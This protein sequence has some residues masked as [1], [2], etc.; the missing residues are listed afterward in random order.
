MVNKK[1]GT[2]KEKRRNCAEKEGKRRREDKELLEKECYVIRK[3]SRKENVG[4][5]R[6]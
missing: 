2:T 4:R 6:I 3:K 5:K 1:K